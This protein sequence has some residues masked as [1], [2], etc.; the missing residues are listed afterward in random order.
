MKMSDMEKKKKIMLLLILAEIVLVIAGT[1]LYSRR[2][3]TDIVFSQEELTL[4][5]GEEG[6]YVDMSFGDKRLQTPILDLPWGIY[7]IEIRYQSEGSVKVYVADAEYGNNNISGNIQL[8]EEGVSTADFWVGYGD[9]GM[10]VYG[11]LRDDAWDGCYLLIDS[12]YI[13][14]SPLAL[15]SFIFYLLLFCLVLDGV[16]AIAMGLARLGIK[17]EDRIAAKLLLLLI[18]A[19]SVPLMMNYLPSSPHDL[20]FHLMRIEGVRAGLESGMLPVRI[21]PNWLGGHGYAVSVFYGDLFLYIPAILRILGMSVQSAYQFYVLLV[22]IATAWLAYYCFSRMTTKKA[23]LFGAMLYSLNIYRLTC[24]Y[25]RAAVGEYTAMVFLPVILYGFWKV[26]R[27]PEGSREQKRSWMT[28]VLGC[29]GVLMCHMITCEMVA[30]FIIAACVLLW[31]KTFRRDVFLTLAKAAGVLF[32]LNIW[33]LVPFLDYMN[34]GTYLIND[35]AEYRPYKLEGRAA[36]VPQL[37]MNVY[38]AKEGSVSSETGIGNEMPMTTGIALLGVLAG[39]FLFDVWNKKEEKKKDRLPHLLAAFGIVS[40]FMVT[41]LM[42]YTGIVKVLPFLELPARSLQ[43]PWRFLTMAGIFLAALGSC[44]LSGEEGNRR[45]RLFAA[46]V[47]CVAFW[48]A[49][50]YTSLFLQNNTPS[51]IYSEGN[52]STYGVSVG[53]YLPLGC[54]TEDLVNQLTYDANAVEVSG[55]ERRGNEI[56]VNA[57]N[58]TEESQQIEVP[59]LYYKGYEAIDQTGENLT[60]FAGQSG[61]M[62]VSLPADFE[63]SFTAAF[64]EPWY[65]RICELISAATAVSMALSGRKF[66]RRQAGKRGIAA[67]E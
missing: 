62:S 53:E 52:L 47:A 14:D 2:K 4:D 50:T 1:Y 12:I 27:L 28:I 43:Y 22:H 10:R 59:F 45:K 58:L 66:F 49:I 25:T 19:E 44:L 20:G 17:D 39:W 33:F 29:T 60:V 8:Y 35:P 65:W 15:R 38:G 16:L 13:M 67:D 36:Y 18:V 7:R 46:A 21:Q 32:L 55:W 6:Y 57:E 41:S 26:Y 61:R 51:Y 63:G 30:L 56:I 48:Q 23:G 40:L 34:S 64:R 24:V 5:T 37:F 9:T 54:N 42:P 3:P 31:K 11:E